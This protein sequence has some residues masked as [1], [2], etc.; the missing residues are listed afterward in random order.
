M[1]HLLEELAER[2]QDVSQH[3]QAR[4]AELRAAADNSLELQQQLLEKADQVANAVSSGGD[5][6]SGEGDT[7]AEVDELRD[8]LQWTRSQLLAAREQLE[9][10][11]A[12]SGDESELLTEL[13]QSR[14]ELD[15]LRRELGDAKSQLESAGQND[16]GESGEAFNERLAEKD[17]AIASLQAQLEAAKTAG[18]EPPV[19]RFASNEEVAAERAKPPPITRGSGTRNCEPPNWKSAWNEQGWQ[20]SVPKWKSVSP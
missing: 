6:G 12:H 11:D 15:D 3:G 1:P 8:E 17:Q 4:L 18:A 9:K 5:S 13:E 2:L 19:D 20:E 7:S 14:R 16:G 10:S